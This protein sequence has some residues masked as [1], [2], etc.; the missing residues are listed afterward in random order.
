MEKRVVITGMGIHSCIGTSLEEVKNSLYDGK[1]GIVLDQ[2]RKDFG[3]QSGLTGRI[4]KP[5]LKPLLKRR[6]RISMGEESEYAFMATIEAFE[7]AKIDQDFI[8]NNEVG[9]IYGNDSVSQSIIE[10]T[11]IM[12]EKKDTALIGSGAIFKSM[13]STITM[14]LSTI[15]RMR[16]VNMTISAACAS[17]SHSIGLAFL[18]I[19]NGLQD[20]VVCGGGQ[21]VNKYA[22]SSFDALGVFSPDEDRPTEACRPF[23]ATRNGLI[24]SGGGATLVVESYESAKK[25][26]AP[27]IAEILG[28]G[29]SSN[30]GHIST[31]NVIGPSTAMR[32]AI[33]QAK[34]SPKD[35]EYIN[36][37]ATS[38]P[39]GDAN[40]AKAIYEV[41]GD[42][43]PY[44]SST[45]SLTGHECW[46]AGASE[47][48]YSTLMMQNDF[49]APNLNF[50]NPDEDAKKINITGKTIDK[51]FD[52]YLS[53][54]FGFGGTN[55]AL[56]LK[57]M[58]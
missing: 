16:G 17:G 1:S 42:N 52:I 21:E 33:E 50:E 44:V 6:Q 24:P 36:A 11:D 45:K 37:H 7:N 55:S 8:D 29:F 28:Y 30:G 5:D 40:E 9:L 19:K 4:P 18:M 38:T 54:S 56:V 57:K 13:N 49:I 22:M 23:D 2:E 32:R 14:N 26:G 31:P 51:K 58:N 47:V 46:M 3:F 53:N 27:I 48:I 25:R 34:L 10:A 15:F 39:I 41:F 35:I 12:R 20:M 43:G